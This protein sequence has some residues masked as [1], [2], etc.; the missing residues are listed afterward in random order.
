MK[1]IIIYLSVWNPT[2]HTHVSRNKSIM[3]KKVSYLIAEGGV[4]IICYFV[5]HSTKWK[6][7]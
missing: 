5:W 3:I 6:F 7:S 1:D 2:L 4:R